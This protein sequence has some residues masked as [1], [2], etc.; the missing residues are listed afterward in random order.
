MKTQERQAATREMRRRLD[1]LQKA[2]AGQDAR[3]A[4]AHAQADTRARVMITPQARERFEL[5][6]TVPERPARAGHAAPAEWSAMR[7]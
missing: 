5:L 1:E 7:C 2:I 4:A 3:L 6:C